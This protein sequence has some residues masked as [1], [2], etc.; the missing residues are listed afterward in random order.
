[1]TTHFYLIRHGET[2]WNAEKKLQGWQDIAL[3]ETGL[4]QAEQLQHYLASEAFSAR[5][6]RLVSSD[7]RRASDTA[8]IASRH[9]GLPIE[10]TDQLRER[11]FGE[12]EGQS[13]ASVGYPDQPN[14]DHTDIDASPQ[15]GESVRV[16]HQRVLNSFEELTA[17]HSGLTVMVFAHGGVI[18][19]VWRKLNQLSLWEPRT[20]SILNTSINHF[21]IDQQGVWNIENWGQLPHLSTA[22][23]E[24]P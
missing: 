20:Q 7:L 4:Q 16:F 13:W 8:R 21:S 1:M 10:M 9:W 17:K 12:L 5:I 2:S 23:D 18:D 15:G 6:D 19:Q 22:L 11:G 24:A 3:N 14:A